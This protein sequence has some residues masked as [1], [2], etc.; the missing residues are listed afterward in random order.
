MAYP[1]AATAYA[2]VMRLSLG[3]RRIHYA[4]IPAS[5]DR[6]VRTLLAHLAHRLSV[7]RAYMHILKT[8]SKASSLDVS[9]KSTCIF[10]M[11]TLVSYFS[12]DILK[13][14]I[15]LNR[16]CQNR[17]SLRQAPAAPHPSQQPPSTVFTAACVVR[18]VNS[19]RGAD[20]MRTVLTV[21]LLA[22]AGGQCCTIVAVGRKA[23]ADGSVMVSHS[24]DAEG[25]GDPRPRRIPAKVCTDAAYPSTNAYKQTGRC[26]FCRTLLY[27]SL[28]FSAW[29]V[30]CLCWRWP[31]DHKHGEERVVYA[32][33]V[34]YPKNPRKLG[35]IP[36]VSHTYAYLQTTYGMMNEKQARRLVV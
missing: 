8:C 11:R 1:R 23:S 33:D 2:R 6:E 12:D 21:L 36:Q 20:L 9:S 25:A 13:T 7:N 18:C 27:Q 26:P 30:M 24:E 15:V 29:S 22:A 34:S 14:K 3:N 31:Q 35:T 19:R 16:V 32:T 4:R 5:R 28:C 17:I 10:I